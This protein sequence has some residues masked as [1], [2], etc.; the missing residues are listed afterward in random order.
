MAA[1]RREDLE[2]HFSEFKAAIE[3]YGIDMADI[4]NKDETGFRIEVITGHVVITHLSAKAVYLTDLD[5]R[6]SLTAVKNI[7]ANSFTIL[8]ILILKV[9]VLLKEILRERS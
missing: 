2:Y 7:S 8:L 6:E 4:Y 5:N 1:H 3:K 9:D